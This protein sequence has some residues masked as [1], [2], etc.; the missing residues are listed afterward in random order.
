MTDAGQADLPKD[1]KYEGFAN[2]NDAIITEL[3]TLLSADVLT[4][5]QDLPD[6]SNR[7]YFW[8]LRTCFQ[9]FVVLNFC[10]IHSLRY[11]GRCRDLKIFI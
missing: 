3:K 9:F 7:S 11:Q 6:I 8:V 5:K 1:G 10:K 4:G 2:V